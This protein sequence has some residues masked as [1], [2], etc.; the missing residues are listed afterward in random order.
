MIVSARMQWASSCM[1]LGI[2]SS[3]MRP[4]AEIKTFKADWRDSNL[5]AA[6]CGRSCQAF[7]WCMSQAHSQLKDARHPAG[8]ER[9]NRTGAQNGSSLAQEGRSINTS[10]SALERLCR[11][12]A[13]PQTKHVSFRDHAL[14]QALQVSSQHLVCLVM[15]KGFWCFY[16]GTAQPQA[17]SPCVPRLLVATLQTDGGRRNVT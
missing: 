3:S 13:S 9:V 16:C 8:S 15:C 10:L 7:V 5:P 6:C 4:F 17:S 11:Q 12:L 14:T 2:L 1:A